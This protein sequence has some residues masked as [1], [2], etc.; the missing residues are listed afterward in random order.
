[1]L[2]D[3]AGVDIAQLTRKIL[4]RRTAPEGPL[5]IVQAGHPA[6]RRRTLAAQ[7]SLDTALL[8]ELVEAMTVTMREAPGVGLAAPQIGLPLRMYV[9]EDRFAPEDE[10]QD[11]P[12]GEPEDQAGSAD[13]SVLHDPL[14]RRPVPLRVFL[15]PQVELLGQQH[16]YAWEGCLSVDGWQ[17]IV[18]RSRRVRLRATELLADDTLQA[19]DEEFVGWP[20][21]IVQHETDHLAGTLCHDRAVPR[22][23]VDAGYTS[24]YAEMPEAV[25]RLGLEGEITQ[26]APGQVLVERSPGETR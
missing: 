1:M 20:A 23:F 2:G 9:I 25:Q 21:R 19:I 4:D 6:L 14:E 15:D 24:L 3:T 10:P 17:S 5:P 12:G 26:L 7:G 13:A 11:E 18:C 8:R 22:S 16:V